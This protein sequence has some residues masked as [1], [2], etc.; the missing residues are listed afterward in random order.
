M[1]KPSRSVS[2]GREAFWGSSLRL[3]RAPAALNP[4]MPM[5]VMAAS[6]H[7]SI[8]LGAKGVNFCAT[9]ACSSGADAIGEACEIIRRGD[10]HM[11]LAGGAEAAITPIGIAG[12]NAAG[13][14]S[15]RN[16]EPQKASRPF[17]TERDGFVMGEGAAV[18]VLESLTYALRRGAH[19]LAEL[20]GYGATSDAHHITQPDASGEGGAKAIQ[21]ALNKAGIHP[22]EIDYIN[23]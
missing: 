16:E 21:G 15:K 4:A 17:D 14:L 22:A 20:G 12:F 9:S 2:K 5:G 13:A 1:T 3:D 19:I 8:M 6:G 10:A 18:M 7:V 23:D 11:M